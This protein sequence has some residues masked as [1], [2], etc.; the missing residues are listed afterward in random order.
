MNKTLA[1]VARLFALTLA[2]ILLTLPVL[3]AESTF[4]TTG[5]A[6]STGIL[7]FARSPLK[8]MTPTPFTLG[9]DG[10]AVVAAQLKVTCDLTMPAMPMP[11]NRPIVAARGDLLT[12][13]AIFT[14]AG[15]WQANF[16]VL[17]PDGR[18]ESLIFDI[19]QV[20]LK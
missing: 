19:P 15:A 16:V 1:D 17:Y 12:G 4:K 5:T 6:G 9:L 14:M 10:T 13:E 3:A 20:N 11:A 2:G 18:K 8:I 7:T